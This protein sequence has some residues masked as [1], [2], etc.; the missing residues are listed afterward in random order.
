MNKKKGYSPLIPQ[1]WRDPRFP[2][3]VGPSR[4]DICEKEATKH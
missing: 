2:A 4:V 1:S 3:L